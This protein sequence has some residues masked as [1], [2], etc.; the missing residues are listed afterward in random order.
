MVSHHDHHR[1][2]AYLVANVDAAGFSQSQQR[3]ISELVLGQRG[4]LRKLEPALDNPQ[5]AWQALCLRL[6][7]IKCHAR[8]AVDTRALQ[9]K[10]DAGAALLNFSPAWAEA[11]PRTLHLLR[12]EAQAWERQGSLKLVLPR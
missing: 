10:Q 7:V 11:H 3:R 1:H 5:F 2:S 8:A 9:L 6:A 4:G 12:E